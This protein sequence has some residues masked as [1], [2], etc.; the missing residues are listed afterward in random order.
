MSVTVASLVQRIRFE[1]GD[2]PWETV[3]TLTNAADTTCAVTDGTDWAKGD[4]GEFVEDGDTFLVQSI[5]SNDLTCVRG[6]WGST[7][8]GH[9]SAR[10]MKNP[11][12]SFDEIKNAISATIQGQLLFP[13]V[14][15]KV[16]DTITPTAGTTWYDLAAT[17]QGLVQAVQLYGTSDSKVGFFGTRHGDF[18]I[19]MERNLPTTLVASGVGVRFPGGFF[20]SSNTVSIDY[21]AK[22]TD[23]IASSEYSDITDGEAVVEAI[24]YG[25]VA[26]LEGALENRKPRKPRHDRETLRGASLYQTKFEDAL[27]MAERECRTNIPLLIKL[28][29]G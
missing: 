13:K 27:A 10:L 23:T 16:A 11:R 1:L 15:K 3:G 19:L 8:A 21:A 29:G 14:Y 12:Y 6:Y 4:I 2:R 5:S 24:I 28:S 7:A 25:A 22:I 9:T 26:H 20:H 18:P 17:A